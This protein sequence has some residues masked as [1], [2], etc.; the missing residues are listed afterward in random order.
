MAWSEG[1]DHLW[2]VW[3]DGFSTFDGQCGIL[4][5]E[6]GKRLGG[7]ATLV[8]ADGDEYYNPANLV[9]FPGPGR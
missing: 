1:A 2:L 5:T 9:L 7:G 8:G 6:L 3:I 4:R